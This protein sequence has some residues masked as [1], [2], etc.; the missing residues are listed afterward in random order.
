MIK[1]TSAS[2]QWLIF[3]STRATSNL[4]DDVVLST[5]IQVEGFSSGMELDFLSNGFKIRGSNNDISYSGK[6]HLYMAFAEA[7]FKYANAR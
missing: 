6:I 2:T 3:D 4:I 1:S 5:T 7:P